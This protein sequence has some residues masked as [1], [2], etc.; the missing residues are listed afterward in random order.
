MPLI[1]R[2]K[3]TL[4][5]SMAISWFGIPSSATL[6]PW[7]MTSSIWRRAG[8]V[9]LISMPTSK[10]PVMPSSRSTSDNAVVATLTARVAPIF[11]AGFS[12]YSFTSVTTT[13]RAPTWRAIAAAITPIGP[14]PV[15]STSSP[16]RSNDNAVCTALPSGSRIG[17]AEIV[18]GVRG[19][20]LR[21]DARLAHGDDGIAQ[22]DDV[23]VTFE[24]SGRELR[25]ERRVT[26]HHRDHRMARPGERDPNAGICSRNHAALA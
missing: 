24:H 16:T 25:G 1:V 8:A 2:P 3:I 20:H 7:F 23:D 26:H 19:R 6:P 14:H 15:M 11:R 22:P 13:W 21:A 10:P 4:F 9:P 5:Q 12:R 17:A 18:L